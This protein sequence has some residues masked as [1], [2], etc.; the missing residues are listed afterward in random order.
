MDIDYISDMASSYN[1]DW[2]ILHHPG[3]FEE[4]MLMVGLDNIETL[5]ICRQVCRKWNSMIMKKIWENPTKKWGAIIQKRIERSWEDQNNLPSDKL[6]S[7]AK[8]LG[9][10]I[11]QA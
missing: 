10:Q 11:A 1:H 3:I 4:I 6:I 5:D 2:L 8:L 7:R 9:E